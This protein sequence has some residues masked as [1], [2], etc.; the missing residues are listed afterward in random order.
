[1]K[2]N[3]ACK[4]PKFKAIPKVT[5][6]EDPIGFLLS[7]MPK[8]LMI[9]N[10]RRC[11]ICKIGEINDLKLREAYNKLFDNGVLREE[12]KIVREKR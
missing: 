7:I 9:N 4:A 2:S 5:Y 11:Y 6:K 1:M 10:L 3:E 8:V 12:Y